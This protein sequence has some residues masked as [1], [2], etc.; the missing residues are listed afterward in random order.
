[1]YNP[2]NK[3]IKEL[4]Y[5]DLEKLIE[6]NISEG[7]HIEYKKVFPKPKKIANSIASF[8][9]SEGGWYIIGI[10][11]NDDEFNPFEIVGFDLETN[12]KPDDR[13]ANIIKGNIEPIPYFENKII[14]TPEN[15]AVLVVQVFEGYD[16][17]YISN[18][19]ICIRV[20][21]TSMPLKIKNRYQFDKLM[22]KKEQYR[23]KINS[24]MNNE[25]YI[26]NNYTQPYLEFYIYVNNPKHYLFEDFY[27]EEFFENLKENFNSNVQLLNDL[28]LSTSVNFDNAYASVDSYILRHIYDNDP[29]QTGLTLELFKEGHLKLILPFNVYDKN[30][31]NKDYESLIYYDYYIL[32]EYDNL[33]II[34]L[35]ESMLAFQ[36]ILSQYKRLLENNNCDY[37][38][39]IKYKFNNFELTT[40]FIDSKEYMEFIYKNKLSINL[41]KSINIPN[42]GYLKCAFQDFDVMAFTIKIIPAMGL[43]TH[44]TEVISKGYGKFIEI[45]FKNK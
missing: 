11:E 35:A 10:K 17:P 26:E 6:N 7:W 15:K 2:F 24:F 23:K 27:S 39:N 13:I 38:L 22:D 18:G 25:F 36:T 9:N 5:E 20:G 30:S 29:L 42:I 45:K 14:E 40:P 28:G 8:A 31:L 21:E 33:R 41:K 3:N 1:M 32:E 19:S 4:E 16:A 12:R 37:E 44:L 34:D 43:T